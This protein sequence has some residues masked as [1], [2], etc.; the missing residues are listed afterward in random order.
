MCKSR[1]IG[2]RH[3]GCRSDQTL[4]IPSP[5][6]ISPVVDFATLQGYDF[7]VAGEPIANQQSALRVPSGSP[8]NPDF[9][10]ELAV[11]AWRSR[12]APAKKLV[13]GI[14]YYGHGWTGVTGGINGLFGAASGPAP[15]TYEHLVVTSGTLVVSTGSDATTLETGDAL[16]FRA[17]V[18]H[19][20]ENPGAVP[21]NAHLVMSYATRT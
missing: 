13:L 6:S 9:S 18:A 20:Y 2:R 14:P 4:S 12:G 5:H 11:S 7:H 3:R 15:G 1:W 10:L 17:D 21:T 8:S 19:R 16:F